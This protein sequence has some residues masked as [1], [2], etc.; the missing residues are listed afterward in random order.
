VLGLPAHVTACLFDL[1]GVLTQTAKVHN[2]AWTETF[3]AFLKDRAA[4]TGEPFRPFDPGPDYNRYVDG[5]PRADGVRSF[6]ASRGITLPEGSP[7]DPP[8]A[9]TVNGVGNRKNIILLKRIETGGV[10]VYP[11]SVRYLEAAARAGL[12]RAVV[13]AS[14]NCAAVVAA[15]GLDR[16]LEARVDGVVAHARGLRGKPHPDTFL[17]GAELLGV[18]PEQAA[19][20]EDALAGVEAGRA[21][22]FG[23]VVGVD[24]VG[25]ADDLRAHGAD[26]VVEDLAELLTGTDA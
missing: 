10:E 9:E 19:V 26:V 4:A 16:L 17:A 25:Q 13:S 3:N 22:G 7:D 6:L 24:R 23:H 21:G 5:K 20:F 11:G 12:R 8:E 14:A 1:D 2:A 18:P 15:A